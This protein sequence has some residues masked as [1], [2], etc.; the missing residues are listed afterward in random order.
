LALLFVTLGFPF[1]VL[2]IVGIK[3]L[4]PH[5][6]SIGW[7]TKVI[8]FL[9]LLSAIMTLIF[10]GM[11]NMRQTAITG[12]F[13]REIPLNITKQDTLYVSMNENPLAGYGPHK[14]DD[15]KIRMCALFSVPHQMR[16]AMSWSMPMPIV[17]P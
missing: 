2:F 1:L 6:R 10:V 14:R 11:Q 8:I 16:M 5:L 7:T 13:D 15:C 12:G 3:L 4:I 17:I 9:V